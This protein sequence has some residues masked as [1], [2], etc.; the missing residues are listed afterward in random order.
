MD[1]IWPCHILFVSLGW[2]GG[3]S[4]DKKRL[5]LLSPILNRGQPTSIPHSYVGEGVSI[6]GSKPP[7]SAL[8]GVAPLPAGGRIPYPQRLLGGCERGTVLSTKYIEF[9]NIFLEKI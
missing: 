3:S 7:Y 4:I 2:M 5:S 1:I 9:E 6:K 8:Y